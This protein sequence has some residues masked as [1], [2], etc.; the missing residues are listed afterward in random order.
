MWWVF[1]EHF[2][3]F[4]C[5]SYARQVP[6]VNE[7]LCMHARF[8]WVC[9]CSFMC[10]FGKKRRNELQMPD[11]VVKWIAN[12]AATLGSHPGTMEIAK[13]SKKQLEHQVPCFFLFL[14]K[15]G[16]CVSECA[17]SMRY[18][19]HWWIPCRLMRGSVR[20]GSP[21][22]DAA[23]LLRNAA[24]LSP[25]L[26]PRASPTFSFHLSFPT[27]WIHS[28]LSSPS[29]FCTLLP[30]PIHPSSHP[31]LHTHCQPPLYLSPSSSANGESVWCLY[32]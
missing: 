19:H 6:Q 25:F 12:W 10:R 16:V 29:L 9:V 2:G 32:F 4:N 15:N 28:Y 5:H 8:L 26:S 17:C 18:V 23:L 21:R 1:N 7:C 27:F 3:Y 24:V 22:R 13:T 11:G 20:S 31:P 14:S 30:Y